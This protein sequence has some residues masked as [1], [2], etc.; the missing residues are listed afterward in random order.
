MNLEIADT[1]IR[2]M[3]ANRKGGIVM[4]KNTAKLMTSDFTG[5]E[6]DMIRELLHIIVKDIMEGVCND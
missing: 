1:Q 3:F 5:A 6:I 2:G 4:P